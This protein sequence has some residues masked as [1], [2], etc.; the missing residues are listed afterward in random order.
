MSGTRFELLD[1]E[2]HRVLLAAGDAPGA[3][4]V[5]QIGPARAD[6]ASERCGSASV[7]LGKRECGRGLADAAARRWCSL[8]GAAL[9]A[10]VEHDGEQRE[11]RR[12]GTRKRFTPAA[13]FGAPRARH[14]RASSRARAI[15]PIG[16]GEATAQRHDEG[17]EPHEVDQRA[18]LRAHAPAAGAEILAQRDEQI[19]APVGVDAG[20]GHAPSAAPSSGA[21]RDAAP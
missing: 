15:A 9:D 16:R 7:R 12:A 19:R 10:D 13:A 3:P 14:R 17:A 4:H 2:Q 5:E 8:S 1:L 18:Q 6:P 21:S 11:Q 20:L